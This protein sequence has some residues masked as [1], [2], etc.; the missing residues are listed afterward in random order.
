MFLVCLDR[1]HQREHRP[2]CMSKA[3]MQLYMRDLSRASPS[4]TACNR[5]ERAIV[6]ESLVLQLNVLFSARAWQ[7]L[8][9]A[10]GR[11]GDSWRGRVASPIPRDYVCPEQRAD[12]TTRR[13]Q[14]TRRRPICVV[15]CSRCWRTAASFAR[16]VWKGNEMGDALIK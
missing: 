6:Q 7:R 8:S 15:V 2:V 10:A 1:F 9:S 11:N 4:R 13:R 5:Q 16:G 12:A 3:S 14:W